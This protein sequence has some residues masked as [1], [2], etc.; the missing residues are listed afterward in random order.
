MI[1]ILRK[2]H[3]W[4]MIV[5]AI[6][7]IPF[8]FYF[9]KTDL[10]AARQTDLGRIYNRPITLV[11]FSRNAHLMNLSRALGMSLGN[12]LMTTN[13]QNEN[14]MYAE[15]T[16]NRLTLQHEVGQL[17]IRPNSKEITDFVKTLSRFAGTG[18]F[19]IDKY[20]E[21]ANETLPAMGFNEAQIEELVSDQLSLNRVKD[22][23]GTGVQVSEAE[24]KENYERAYGKMD[25]AV[26][27][28][29]DE[30]FEKDINISDEDIAK[31]YEA[32][33]AQ[34]KSEE[35]RRVEFVTFALTEDEKK[36]TGKERV[37]P[38][39]KVA[40]RANDFTQ[41][42]LEKDAKFE[43]V[44]AKFKTP[45]VST[46]EFT[47]ASP[48]LKLASNPQLTQSSFQL[49][50]QAP[51]SDPVQGPDGFSI[52][53]LLAVTESHPFSLDEAKPKIIEA[54]KAERL[55]ELVNNKAAAIGQQLRDAV[56]AKTPLE[57]VA[58]ANGLN[59]E[60]IPS[61]SLVETPVKLEADEETLKAE[62]T[63]VATPK[64]VTAASVKLEPVTAKDAKSKDEKPADAKVADA[65]TKDPNAKEAASKEE[66]PADVKVAD[67]KTK[68]PNAKEVASKEEKP[69]DIKLADAKAKDPKPKDAKPK[70]ETPGLPAIK[71]AVAVLNAG[72]VTDFIPQEKGGMVAVL[73]KRAPA[74]PSGFEAATAQA[75]T[76]YLS[77]GRTRAFI[78][79]LRD[80]RKA[81]D[82]K[83]GNS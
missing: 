19:D 48:D 83:M 40:D 30:D 5:I 80:R 26:V 55:R 64:G 34:L 41:A 7:A 22:L 82:V 31:Y 2:H 9:N 14:D 29:R 42:M 39:Q 73:E 62:T 12:D 59:L 21:F 74:D 47:T 79:W 60:R 53:H 67:A 49:T 10:G 15:F 35:K 56:K 71:N 44:A 46:G 54:L 27:R 23:L 33:K 38:L 43:E 61:F 4:L 45:V 8:V 78:E 57:H 11:E 32:H 66:K 18:G 65:K 24:S 63:E 36:L 68:D 37:D 1:T 52:V 76:Q 3:R 72:D 20:N 70:V 51:F 81:A 6:L 50:E 75:Q 25:V 16:W 58:Q 28:L 13:V 77:Q 17:G 69:A